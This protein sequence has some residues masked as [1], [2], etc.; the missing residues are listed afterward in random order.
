MYGTTS[1]FEE[2]ESLFSADLTHLD[3][4][5]LIQMDCTFMGD[6]SLTK[7][8]FGNNYPNKDLKY[9]SSLFYGCSSLTSVDFGKFDTSKVE[10]FDSM[11][12]NCEKLEKL[13]LS[14]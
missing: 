9:M 6:I 5:Y 8:V 2:C 7:V 10:Y 3:T 4:T 12:N 1:L 11:F 13:E 14:S